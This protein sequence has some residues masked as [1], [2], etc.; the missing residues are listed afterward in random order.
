MPAPIVSPGHRG[1]ESRALGRDVRGA[2]TTEYVIVV[3]AVSLVVAGALL[4]IGPK[5]VTSFAHASATLGSAS[6]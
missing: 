2:V 6:P 3:G 5:L 1:R 4:G